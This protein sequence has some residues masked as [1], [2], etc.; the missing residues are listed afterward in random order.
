MYKLNEIGPKIEPCGTP[1][2]QSRNGEHA[3]LILVH[4]FLKFK[5]D[6]IHVNVL[7]SLL[8]DKRMLTSHRATHLHKSVAIRVKKLK[9]KRDMFSGSLNRY[10]VMHLLLN[11]RIL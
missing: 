8:K 2:L 5:Y 4:C 11:E 6:S 7:V 1:M 10:A 3:L 9:P